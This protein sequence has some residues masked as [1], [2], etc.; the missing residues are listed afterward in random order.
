MSLYSVAFIVAALAG[1]WPHSLFDTSKYD[2]LVTHALWV[3]HMTK[4]IELMD[5]VFMILRHR[6]RQMTLLHVSSQPLAIH[7]T[8]SDRAKSKLFPRVET[9]F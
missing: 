1:N 2:P 5:T 3:Y 7:D 9:G 4:Y 8:L 6:R